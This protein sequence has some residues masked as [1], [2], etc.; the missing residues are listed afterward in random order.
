MDNAFVPFRG[1]SIPLFVYFLL[2]SEAPP[3]IWVIEEG[4]EKATEESI[5]VLRLL[6]HWHNCVY[7]VDDLDA[8]LGYQYNIA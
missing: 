6:C 7:F 8:S 5:C 2:E 3:R 1:C 4:G